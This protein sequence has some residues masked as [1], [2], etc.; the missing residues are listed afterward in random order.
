MT[1]PTHGA[2][3]GGSGV[4]EVA[5]R[6]LVDER[7]DRLTTDAVE[8]VLADEPEYARSLVSRS[9]LHRQMRRTLA[10][11]LL[12][13]AGDPLPQDL[14]TAA[15]E[16]GR[17]RAEQ[18]LPLDALLHSYRIDLR[19][20]W[21]AL[22]NESRTGELSSDER[23]VAAFLLAWES[24]E[25]NTTEAAEAYR[26][27]LEDKTRSRDALR[28]RAFER[29]VSTRGIDAATIRDAAQLL[30]LPERT[31]LLVVVGDGIPADGA[32]Q[33]AL[34][35]RLR[36]RSVPAHFG[37]VGDTFIG[38]ASLDGREV[39]GLLDMLSPLTEW[40]SGAAVVDDLASAAL[41]VDLALTMARTAAAPGLRLLNHNWPAGAVQASGEFGGVLGEEVLGRLLALPPRERSAVL[42]TL[43]AYVDGSGSVS[44][45]AKRTHCHRNTVRNRL[46]QAESL[47]G[48]SLAR[49]KD[50]ATLVLAMEWC[51]GREGNHWASTV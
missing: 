29:L 8:R 48:L 20:L 13:L 42:R 47:T 4:R 5:R 25:A 35:A 7:L 44:E 38:I 50:L 49:P 51:R 27:A 34:S 41:G 14:A 30:N 17:L 21:T 36:A 15:T 12:R 39:D 24:V 18:G 16:V 9:D 2:Q 1:V 3:A 31:P 37:W 10:L 11:A 40:R 19:I 6:L 45:V 28:G 23:Q 46:R 33:V 32:L 43:A 26:A 22:V